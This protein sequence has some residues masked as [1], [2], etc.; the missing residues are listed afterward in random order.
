ME[1]FK[2]YGFKHTMNMVRNDS[3]NAHVFL[4]YKMLL[5]GLINDFNQMLV[6]CI[7]EQKPGIHK[8]IEHCNVIRME[9]FK[10]DDIDE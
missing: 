7:K 2:K 10:K 6:T 8:C 9:H 3:N 1:L 4:G 5:D